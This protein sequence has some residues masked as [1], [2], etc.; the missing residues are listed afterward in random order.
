MGGV[1]DEEA[2]LGGGG[3]GVRGGPVCAAERHL[4][5]GFGGH[6]E[7]GGVEG[8]G[9]HVVEEGLEGGGVARRGERGGGR[10]RGG[11]GWAEG[12]S[13][14]PIISG[15]G[16]VEDVVWTDGNA[17][18]HVEGGAKGGAGSVTGEA[19]VPIVAAR[20]CFHGARGL[21]QDEDAVHARVENEDGAGIVNGDAER[22]Q[23]VEKVQP[24]AR[25]SGDDLSGGRDAANRVV[26]RVAKIYVKRSV[27]C[28]TA[29]VAA[30][31]GDRRGAIVTRIA[32][33][34]SA[35]EGRNVTRCGGNDAEAVVAG[36]DQVQVK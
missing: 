11:T 34:T 35:G 9:E 27:N 30:D 12:E 31:L 4:T 7:D 10:E 3:V 18:R 1:G 25:D 2:L 13:A 5:C 19:A 17:G 32:R 14:H 8:A 16:K 15:V 6:A 23:K 29:G 26:P 20:N 24:V 33:R 36:I 21:T 22:G 28:D